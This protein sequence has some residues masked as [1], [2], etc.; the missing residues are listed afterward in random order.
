MAFKGASKGQ[1][2]KATDAVKA[3]PSEKSKKARQEPEDAEMDSPDLDG[4]DGLSDSDS[5][6]GV[7]LESP[8]HKKAKTSA[9][10][11]K[12][13]LP[14]R[15]HGADKQNA[16]QPGRQSLGLTGPC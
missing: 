10:G 12:T 8:K 14:D 7:P 5:D 6:G 3:I 15:T 1:K 16:L 13:S 9:N 2:R 4:F 11:A